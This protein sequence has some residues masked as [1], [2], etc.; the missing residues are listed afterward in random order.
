MKLTVLREKLAVGMTFVG[1]FIGKNRE[2]CRPEN[3]QAKR[4]VQKQS[5]TEMLC[6]FIEHLNAGEETYLA[7]KGT[8]ARQEGDAIILTK[9]G[10]DFL[11]ITDIQASERPVVATCKQLAESLRSWPSVLSV[12]IA[13]ENRQDILIVYT[14]Q[15]LSDA[16]VPRA[17]EGYKVRQ[18]T[19]GEVSPA[20]EE[21]E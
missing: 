4:L 21:E 10:E 16:I 12:G 13:N 3:I 6:Q 9:Y 18:C 5:G 2:R 19:T 20:P 17:Y 1:E 7:W 15:K 14:V 8:T 11:R